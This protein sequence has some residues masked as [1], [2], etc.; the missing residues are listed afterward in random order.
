MMV[1]GKLADMRRAIWILPLL[2]IGLA[3]CASSPK[4]R[5]Q[6]DPGA[7]FSSYRTFGFL[8]ESTGAKPAYASF[9]AQYLKKAVTREM[10]ARGISPSDNPDLLVNF[11]LVTK[12]KV[13]VSQTP[14]AY[15][16]YRRGYSWGGMSTATTDVSSFTEG[17]LNVDVVDRSKMQ[18]VWEA[19]AVG[20]VTDKAL[21]NP[22]PAISQVITQLFE[23]FP[24][25]AGSSSPSI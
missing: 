2:C 7:D 19:T 5:S 10:Q 1:L 16:G 13:Q 4:I 15:Y 11:N 3:S 6:S 8:D 22:E 12:D 18:L 21:E 9:V 14:S 17:T 23:K 20:R 25:A 24:R